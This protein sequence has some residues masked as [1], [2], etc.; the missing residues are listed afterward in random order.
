MPSIHMMGNTWNENKYN[1]HLN[2]KKHTTR[3]HT[4]KG[5]ICLSDSTGSSSMV[6][7]SLM[8][9]GPPPSD[10]TSPQHLVNRREGG[11][12]EY[13][14]T[15]KSKYWYIIILLCLDRYKYR[16]LL[17]ACIILQ[18]NFWFVNVLFLWLL[19]YWCIL[20]HYMLF[21]LFICNKEQCLH[22]NS[23]LPKIVF[24]CFFNKMSR[25]TYWYMHSLC[26]FHSSVTLYNT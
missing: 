6:Q 26:N 10:H 13:G 4:H 22:R 24:I 20:Q 11:R 25:I 18:N 16:V 2:R 7:C 17:T 8:W 5:G 12:E 19:H 1:A 21:C 3:A 23:G 15:A 9:R 14:A